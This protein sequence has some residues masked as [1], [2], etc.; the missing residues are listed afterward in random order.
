ML[1]AILVYLGATPGTTA[2]VTEAT[3]DANGDALGPV[4]TNLA[5]PVAGAAITCY[6]EADAVHATP[7]YST[8]TEGDGGFSLTVALGATYRVGCTHS[9]Y[10][11]A[12]REVTV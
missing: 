5:V 3:L 4:E 1:A 2:T 6:A 11:W 7:L 12:D 8:I 9:G 10:S